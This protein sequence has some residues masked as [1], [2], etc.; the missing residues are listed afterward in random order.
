[1]HMLIHRRIHIQIHIHIHIQIQ[2]QIHIQI[3]MHIHIHIHIHIYIYILPKVLRL[4]A[5][6][7]EVVGI[8]G[9]RVLKCGR[10]C[11]FQCL[12]FRE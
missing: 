8:F 9:F 2:I 3:R 7:F 4:R 1:M 5:I 12:G 6:A 10:A 11:R